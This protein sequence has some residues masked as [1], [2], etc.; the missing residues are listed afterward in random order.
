MSSVLR[1]M[2]LTAET[3]TAATISHATNL[4]I[5][6]LTASMARLI[7]SSRFTPNSPKGDGRFCLCVFYMARR[8]AFPHLA[9]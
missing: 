2:A 8:P 5:L 7:L 4:P 6:R 3:S 1:R 9:P